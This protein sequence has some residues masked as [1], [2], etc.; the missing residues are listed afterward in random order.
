MESREVPWQR[1]STGHWYSPARFGRKWKYSWLL[2]PISVLN[3]TI[4]KIRPV[5]RK[6]YSINCSQM[7]HII[8][9]NCW[10]CLRL[11]S[12]I[13]INSGNKTYLLL[14][15]PWNLIPCLT[16]SFTST[17]LPFLLFDV[18]LNHL[19]MVLQKVGW[20]KKKPELKHKYPVSKW[21]LLVYILANALYRYC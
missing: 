14:L 4:N 2:F 3:P 8:T 5:T 20:T 21:R 17:R 11:Y 19:V 16:L 18:L 7:I 15:K 10:H 13:Y 12:L 6:L 9:G 1:S